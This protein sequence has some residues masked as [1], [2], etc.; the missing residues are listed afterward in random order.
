[1]SLWNDDLHRRHIIGVGNGMIHDADASDDLPNRLNLPRVS[2]F[3]HIRRAAD[4]HLG[5]ADF[6]A[7]NNCLDLSC[8]I[9]L[10]LINVLVEHEGASEDS[11][12]S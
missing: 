11:A 5:L 6:I 10:D 4:D 3:K 9:E 2:R 8:F 7:R 1:M 12:H